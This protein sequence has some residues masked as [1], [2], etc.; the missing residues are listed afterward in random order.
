MSQIWI[1]VA[2]LAISLIFGDLLKITQSLNIVHVNGSYAPEPIDI[3]VAER[4]LRAGAEM[5]KLTDKALWAFT[6][7]RRRMEDTFEMVRIAR[8]RTLE[9]MLNE[10]SFYSVVYTNSPLQLDRPMAT[11]IIEMARLGQALCITPF[12]LAG[13]M[14]PVTLAGALVQQNAEAL[15]G[16]VLSQ[17]VRR[18][19]PLIYGGFT[20]NVDMRSGSPAFGTPEYVSAPPS[21]A[22]SSHVVMGSPVPVIQCECCKCPRTLRPLGRA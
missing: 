12:T 8:G 1:A 16:I 5:L 13:A 20:S 3:E 9:E 17:L 7:T 11:G 14:A 15:A 6:F 2:G 10:P 19:A 18:G 22:A 21:L 4:H